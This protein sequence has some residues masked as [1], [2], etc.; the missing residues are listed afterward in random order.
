VAEFRQFGP[1]SNAIK[2]RGGPHRENKGGTILAMGMG[3]MKMEK[4]KRGS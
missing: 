2:R 4:E 3:Q 1:A